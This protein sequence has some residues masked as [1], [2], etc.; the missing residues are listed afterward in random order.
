MQFGLCNAPVV[1][2]ATEPDEPAQTKGQSR[3]GLIRLPTNAIEGMSQV[4]KTP[5][6]KQSNSTDHDGK[7]RLI[8]MGKLCRRALMLIKYKVG[9]DEAVD[10][11]MV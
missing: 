11:C 9:T 4:L 3:P 6:T 7:S 8:L 1:I 10:D 5:P 2:I